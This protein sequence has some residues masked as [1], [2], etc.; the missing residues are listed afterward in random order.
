MWLNITEL[1]VEVGGFAFV[2]R[3]AFL[4]ESVDTFLIVFA[5]VH[6]RAIGVDAL[7]TLGRHRSSGLAEDAELAFDGR[8][9]EDRVA[10]EWGTEFLLEQVVELFNGCDMV[11]ET[12]VER[13]LRR[14]RI[15]GEEHLASLIDAEL[16]DEVH[17]T[18]RVVRD[19]DFRGCDSESGSVSRNNH[20]A[21]EA[22][23]ARATPDGSIGA[24]DDR[25]RYILYLTQQLFHGHF[26]GQ[27]VGAVGWQFVDVMSGR[28]DTVFALG[29][30]DDTYAL[31]GIGFVDSI[32]EL[33]THGLA[34]AVEMVGILH[35]NPCDAVVDV[36][37]NHRSFVKIMRKSSTFFGNTQGKSAK[38][39]H[40]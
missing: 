12:Y 37:I 29:S 5:A 14:D 7:K 26:V 2:L 16:V 30:E 28:P 8:D 9:A 3:W 36:E 17:D 35:G 1:L 33:G 38:N 15:G 21:T 34:Q 18:G 11:N 22:Q 24:S 4:E 23:V 10:T 40:N 13:I 32:D 25:N 39:L 27:R 31:F 20:V 6:A 19:A